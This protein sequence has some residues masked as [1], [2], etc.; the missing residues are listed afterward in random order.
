MGRHEVNVRGDG[1][2]FYRAMALAVDEK[3]DH[4]KLNQ[5]FEPCV[6]K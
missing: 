5:C 1:N 2:C 4:A 6:M 3:T